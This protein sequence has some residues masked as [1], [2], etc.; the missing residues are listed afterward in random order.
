MPRLPKHQL[1]SV[2][3]VA[4]GLDGLLPHGRHPQCAARNSVETVARTGIGFMGV[5]LHGPHRLWTCSRPDLKLNFAIS[6]AEIIQTLK[7][8]MKSLASRIPLAQ[9]TRKSVAN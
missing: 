9:D 1:A 3:G 8:L 6:G 4:H 2:S 7:I 5:D